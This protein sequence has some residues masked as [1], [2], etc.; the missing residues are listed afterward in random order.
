[1]YVY[2]LMCVCISV[3][4]CIRCVLVCLFMRVCVYCVCI[5]ICVVCMLNYI[6]ELYKQ[7]LQCCICYRIYAIASQLSPVDHSS[8]IE[9]LEADTFSLYCFQ[10]LTG[11]C[12]WEV[13]D[14]R[15][16]EHLFICGIAS[17]FLALQSYVYLK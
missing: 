9:Y 17:T 11:N 10:T 1:M 15:Y 2:V 3:G 14:T 6:R 5:C 4:M 8:G 12:I 7:Y 16:V 13:S